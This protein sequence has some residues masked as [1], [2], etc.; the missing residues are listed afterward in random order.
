MT[1]KTIASVG[2]ALILTALATTANART[3]PNV[4]IF[5]RHA[6][7]GGYTYQPAVKVARH[8]KAKRKHY[9]RGD[10]IPRKYAKHRN[11]GQTVSLDAVT[12]K[13]AAKAREIIADCGAKVISAYRPGARVRGY[14]T[15]SLHSRYPAEAVDMTGNTSCI[16]PHLRGWPG[17]YS[18]DY[19]AVQH[20]HIS[21][22]SDRRERGARFSHYGTRRYARR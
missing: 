16:Y 8:V 2:L 9:E 6:L 18:V 15:A 19:A 3:T 10:N 17:G 12:P 5:D 13:L 4:T 7:D 22:A 1:S 11:G 20:V 14:G 21:L